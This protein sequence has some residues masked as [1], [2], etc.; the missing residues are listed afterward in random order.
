VER[1]E[2]MKEVRDVLEEGGRLGK[3]CLDAGGG[4]VEEE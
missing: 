4:V 1:E 3:G 2:R